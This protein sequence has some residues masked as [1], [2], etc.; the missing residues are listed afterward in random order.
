MEDIINECRVAFIISD[1]TS[2]CEKLCRDCDEFFAQFSKDDHS[3]NNHRYS[4]DIKFVPDQN[5]YRWHQLSE[6]KKL[7]LS[8]STSSY[9]SYQSESV[10][11]SVPDLVNEIPIPSPTVIDRSRKSALTIALEKTQMNGKS[12]N[13][14]T[15]FAV[16]DGRSADGRSNCVPHSSS[17]TL[18][19][20]NVCF[21]NISGIPKTSISLQPTESCTVRDFIGLALWQYFNENPSDIATFNEKPSHLEQDAKAIIEQIKVYMMETSDEVEDLPP[22]ELGDLIYKYDFEGYALKENAIVVATTEP[23]IV[24]TVKFIC[25]ELDVIL[26]WLPH[27][28]T[29]SLAFMFVLRCGNLR[30]YLPWMLKCS[31]KH[32]DFTF[33]FPLSTNSDLKTQADLNLPNPTCA[34][35]IISNGL[36]SLDSII[37]SESELT[38]AFSRTPPLFFFLASFTTCCNIIEDVVNSISTTLYGGNRKTRLETLHLA[39]GIS[40]V[41]LPPSAT[42]ECV[43]NDVLNRRMLRQHQGYAYRLEEWVDPDKKSTGGGEEAVV[44]RKPLDL[45]MTIAEY[46]KNYASTHFALIREHST[47]S[48]FYC[49]CVCVRACLFD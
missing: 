16:F 42:L 21:W 35:L 47:F 9:Q 4:P 39:Q 38:L 22:F 3:P 11:E 33:T 25:D 13:K 7:T 30:H 17:F 1:D 6:Q 32:A 27:Q 49:V 20:F 36:D 12:I 40:R 18:R 2:Q 46:T 45:S 10:A 31:E 37:G 29:K 48:S 19:P 26:D 34:I 15:D 24:F 43:V 5:F 14:F 41:H 8:N 23:S 28:C 44:A